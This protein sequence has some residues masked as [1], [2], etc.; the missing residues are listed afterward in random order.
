M[1]RTRGS[2]DGSGEPANHVRREEMA[3]G[4]F[5]SVTGLQKLSG[6]TYAFIGR[7]GEP[8]HGFLV[9]EK[10]VIVI[11]NDIRYIEKFMA[12]IRKTTRRKIKFLINTHHAFDHTS[13][14]QL[15]REEGA[16]IISSLKAREHLA[17]VGAKKI[18][19]MG[20]RDDTLRKLTRGLKLTLPDVA[21]DHRLSLYLAS[22]QV[23]LIFVGH[24]HSVGD[25]VVYIPE[26]KVVFA[27]DLVVNNYHPNIRDG[28]MENWLQAL[29]LIYDLPVK[30]IVPGHGPLIRGKEQCR[31]IK[32]YFLAVKDTVQKQVRQGKALEEIRRD[33]SLPAYAAWA[34]PQ[35][36][37]ITIE[38]I[39]RESAP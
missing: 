14:N 12:A 21:F 8:N 22:E 17:N 33:F 37:E 24:C 38:K 19:D 28:N 35:W 7:N 30:F 36:L 20:K 32:E 5:D 16:V 27:G 23:E 3:K 13:A 11:D 26:E 25:A 18:V 9:T 10:G 4:T 1:R 29:D 39:Y 34:K 6:K 2:N 31:I 15:F